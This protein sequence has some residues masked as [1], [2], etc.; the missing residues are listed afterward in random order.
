M[1][2]YRYYPTRLVI[3]K[4]ILRQFRG[5][6]ETLWYSVCWSEVH[7]YQNHWFISSNPRINGDTNVLLF[8]LK[9]TKYVIINGFQVNENALPNHLRGLI[10]H[11]QCLRGE[12]TTLY[13]WPTMSQLFV[14]RAIVVIVNNNNNNNNNNNILTTVFFIGMWN[15]E[16]NNNIRTKN[17]NNKQTN[18]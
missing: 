7:L 14:Q 5:K 11:W 18:I 6:R 2:H 8:I 1:K 13:Q 9:S 3:L 16:K 15:V 4:R 12:G 10:S 17:P